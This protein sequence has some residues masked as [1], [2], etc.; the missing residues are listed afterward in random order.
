M[1][2]IKRDWVDIVEMQLGYQI[3]DDD[4]N[5]K[6]F[7]LAMKS[8]IC[9]ELN[10]KTKETNALRKEILKLRIELGKRDW[11]GDSNGKI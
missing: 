4:Y 3:I 2:K 1:T 7:N 8:I 9:K 6:L 5:L 11:N 10:M